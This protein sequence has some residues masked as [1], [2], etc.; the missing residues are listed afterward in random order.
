MKSKLQPPRKRLHWLLPGAIVLAV[1]PMFVFASMY[2]HWFAA[3]LPG[4]LNGPAD[5]YRHSL[6][7]ATVAYTGSR[8]GSSG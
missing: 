4:G 3:A 1:Y 8:V 2:S 5:G 6:A 7:S